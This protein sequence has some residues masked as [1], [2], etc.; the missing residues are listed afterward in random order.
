M[1]D[2]PL[3]QRLTE[4]RRGVLDAPSQARAQ[5]CKALEESLHV[6]IAPALLQHAGERGL[7]CGEGAPGVAK[8]GELHLIVVLEAARVA[9]RTLTWPPCESTV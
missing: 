8:V 1:R 3:C 5:E 4:L 6:R 9:H 2:Q 7:L